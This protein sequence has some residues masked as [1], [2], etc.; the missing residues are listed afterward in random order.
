M[1]DLIELINIAADKKP[2]MGQDCNHCG[3]CCMTEVCE[4]GQAAT[5]SSRYAI[6]CS[7]LVETDGKYLCSLADTPNPDMGFGTGCCAQTQDEALQAMM[8]GA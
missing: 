6:P 3:W 1:S 5:G 8:E 2:A 4:M 7:Q